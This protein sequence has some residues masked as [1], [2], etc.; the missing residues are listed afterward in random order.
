MP[1]SVDF[2]PVCDLLFNFISVAT[3]FCDVAF[4]VIVAYTAFH[5][6]QPGWFYLF[7]FLLVSSV[8]LCH[9][10][11]IKWYVDEDE[12]HRGLSTAF[13]LG[14]HL[15]LGGVF[16]RYGRLLFA[17]IDIAVVKREMS[18]LSVIR[19]VHGFAQGVPSL[20]AKGYLIATF[21]SGSGSGAQTEAHLQILYVSAALSLFSICWGLASFNKNIRP[22]TMHKLI[23]TWIGVISQ[24]LWRLGTVSARVLALVLYASVYHAWLLV[25]ALLHWLCMF[26]WLLFMRKNEMSLMGAADGGGSSASDAASEKKKRTQ[27]NLKAALS[28]TLLSVVYMV[29][30]LNM[31]HTPTVVRMALYYAVALIENLLL[32]SLWCAHIQTTLQYSAEERVRAFFSAMAPFVAGVVFMVLYYKIFHVSK[33]KSDL[34]VSDADGAPVGGGRAG[35]G[36]PGAANGDTVFNC[37]LNPALRKK[38]KIPRNIPPPPPGQGQKAATAFWKEPLPAP[39]TPPLSS[40]VYDGSPDG[41]MHNL[42]NDRLANDR[43]D[44]SG[45]HGKGPREKKA[46]SI[47]AYTI[48]TILD[49]CNSSQHIYSFWFDYNYYNGFHAPFYFLPR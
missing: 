4:D 21:G 43:F 28:C 15:A 6:A 23:L 32:F 25:F 26:L 8:F 31:E 33:T 34:G 7:F 45:E 41:P 10:I 24:F 16:W 17:P 14:V 9:V 40:G 44:S 30:F 12:S 39:A 36:P 35:C 20:V 29:D 11:S 13:V 1:S 48:K 37:A 5:F 18:C 3:Y 46:F 27:L 42:G 49:Y 22:K 2:L 38:K 47:H 19:M